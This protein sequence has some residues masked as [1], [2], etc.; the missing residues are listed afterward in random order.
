MIVASKLA[1]TAKKQL[2][3]FCHYSVILRKLVIRGFPPRFEF[4]EGK[5]TSGLS[6]EL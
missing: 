6:E 5:V 3:R 2:W 4:G 1:I